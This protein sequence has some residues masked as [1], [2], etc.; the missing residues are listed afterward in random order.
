MAY[1]T[2]GDPIPEKGKGSK[3]S[4][5]MALFVREYL[6]D[7]NA[8]KACLRAGYKTKDPN[9]YGMKLMKHPLISKEI[10]KHQQKKFERLELSADYV[11]NKLISIVEETDASNPQAALRGLE[12]LGKHLGLYRERQEISGPDGDAIRYEQKIKEDNLAIESAIAR[13]SSRGGAENVVE[14]P[15]GAATG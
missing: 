5:K 10:E 3:L 12:L 15:D 8:S 14:F 4:G 7:Y 13:L 6:V 1:L 11:I 2:K 9:I